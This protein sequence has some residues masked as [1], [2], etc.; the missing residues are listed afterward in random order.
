L[1]YSYLKRKK[2]WTIVKKVIGLKETQSE[3]KEKQGSTVKRELNEEK[4]AK[5][6]NP[7]ISR[8]GR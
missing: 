2:L 5:K 4:K 3:A 6:T 1:N 8:P 7:L